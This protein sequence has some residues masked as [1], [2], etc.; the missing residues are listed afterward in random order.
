[1]AKLSSLKVDVDK[2]IHGAWLDYEDGVRLRVTSTLA[3][4]YRDALR[5][6]V[7]AKKVELRSTTITDDQWDECRRSVAYTLLTDWANIEDDDGKSIAYSPKVAKA[8]AS[9]PELH[10][11]WGWVLYQAEAFRNF[12]KTVQADAAKN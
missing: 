8:W 9:D 1:M 4:S 2:E 11:L 12:R 5:A 10:L 6:A 7:A 3:P